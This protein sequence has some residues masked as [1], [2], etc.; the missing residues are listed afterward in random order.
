MARLR[1]PLAWLAAAV[2]ACIAVAAAYVPP[3]GVSA[4]RRAT[5]SGVL[6]GP[7]TP[8]RLRANELAKEWRRAALDVR[9][10]EVRQ[11][12]APELA[13]R[14]AANAL[15]LVVRIDSTWSLA[16][17]E[18]LTAA[19]EQAWRTLGL[20]VSKIG[21][22]VVIEPERMSARAPGNLV[23]AFLL[24]DSTDRHT[25]VAWTASRALPQRTFEREEK[26]FASARSHFAH[27]LLGPCAFYAKFGA[28]GEGIERWLA[29]HRYRY[30]LLPAWDSTT[31][32]WSRPWYERPR[33]WIERE[34]FE[35]WVFQEFPAM[36]LGCMAERARAC[37]DVVVGT[38]PAYGPIPRTL[39]GSDERSAHL[40]WSNSLLSE[41]V[42]DRG[43]A[44]FGRF[45]GST[46]PVDSAFHVAMD[47]TLGE[48]VLSRQQAHE[49]TLRAGPAPAGGSALFGLSVAALCLAAA[50]TAATRRQV[51]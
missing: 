6:T 27:G 11:Q 45:W 4:E 8:E 1:G 38:V 19:V 32:D 20:D 49:T 40:P 2:L 9:L 29:A 31:S 23:N 48:W 15:S 3:R 43:A 50:V 18:R 14:R 30:A 41:L 37:R 17:R 33:S 47:T 10:H 13:R 24:P 39:A 7:P 12:A 22:A 21:V 28:P 34:R 35:R 36:A 5:L 46:L 26:R 51:S 25:C 44:R 16:A 42:M